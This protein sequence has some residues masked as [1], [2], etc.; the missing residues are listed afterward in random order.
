WQKSED[1]ARGTGLGLFI[2]KGVIESHGGR[3]W[4]ESVPGEGS[5]FRFTLPTA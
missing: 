2:V 5:D 3:V 4:V 1:A